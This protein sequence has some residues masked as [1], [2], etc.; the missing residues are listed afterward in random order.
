MKTSTGITIASLALSVLGTPLALVAMSSGIVPGFV[1]ASVVDVPVAATTLQTQADLPGLPV[2]AT[3]E[4]V[5]QPVRLISAREARERGK[6]ELAIHDYLASI[7]EDP[8][9]A[10]S[11]I[12]ELTEVLLK[13][14]KTHGDAEHFVD[15]SKELNL[16]FRIL[17]QL[18]QA[19]ASTKPL[20][21][22][23]RL[24]LF[25][26]KARTESACRDAAKGHL[27]AADMLR[28]SAKGRNWWN[29]DNEN[30]QAQALH[31]VNLAWSYYPYHVD[32]GVV[33]KLYEIWADS[34][35]E[36]PTWQYTQVMESDRLQLG[37][38]MGDQQ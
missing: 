26:E 28:R 5:P 20:T 8:T 4:A 7:D 21:E 32:E 15:Q 23:A 38:V 9:T 2:P 11:S 22:A 29:D 18:Q 6:R 1:N 27:D 36:L 3:T 16:C 13:S 25:E 33:G 30:E 34:K 10:D 31:K 19:D 35:S 12:A 24:R 37:R 17:Q 14:A